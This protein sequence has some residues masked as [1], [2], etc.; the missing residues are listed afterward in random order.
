MF[1]MRGATHRIQENL[2]SLRARMDAARL[3]SPHAAPHCDLLVVSKSVPTWMF[4][5][6]AAAGVGAVGENRVQPAAARKAEGPPE[7]TWHGIGHLQ[8]NKAKLAVETFDVFH[9]LDSLRLAEHLE[10]VLGSIG[11]RWPVYLQ[12]NTA[13]DPA[14]GGFP[15]DG[16]PEALAALQALPHLELVGFM[17][18]GRLGAAK[19]DQRATFRT[20]RAVRDEAVRPDGGFASAVG[21]SMGMT[22]DFEIAVEEGATVV[23]V[24][25]AVFEG[26]PTTEAEARGLGGIETDGNSSSTETH[27]EHR[28]PR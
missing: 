21:L 15:P 22:D 14:K 8:R 1:P 7:W 9:A 17:T 12:V 24:G 6:L 18:M 3:R 10:G 11:R 26:I 27:R 13:G 19:R 5:P 28:E 2:A 16:V 23:R 20:L 4:G 25:R